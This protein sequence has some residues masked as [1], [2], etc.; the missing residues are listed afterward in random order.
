MEPGQ[1][2]EVDC[3]FVRDP[4]REQDEDGVITTLTW[5]PGVIWEMVGPEDAR[6][7]AHGVGRVRYTVVSVHNLPRPYPARVFFLRKWISPEG[8]EFGANKLHVMTRDAFR[9]RCHSYQ[10]A[11]ADQWTEL[12]VEDMSADEREKALGQ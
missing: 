10:P 2:F 12:V 9:R 4:Y 6:A 1:T 5:K 7:R 8:R 3:P 11:G